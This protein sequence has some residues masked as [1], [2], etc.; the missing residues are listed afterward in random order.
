MPAT[1]FSW[2]GEP[3]VLGSLSTIATD[4]PDFTEASSTVG[5][6]VAQLEMG[7]TYTR[8]A[9]IDAHS[10][11][12]L[13]LRYGVFANWL[14]LR[15][16]VSPVSVVSDGTYSGAEDLYLGTKLWLMQ[17]DEW[18]PEVAVVYQMTV[19]TGSPAFTSG[20]VLP[21][22]NVLY[23]WDISD[24]FSLAGST[25]YNRAV[26][27]ESELYDE[28]S[29]SATVGVSLLDNVG[30]Y[31]EWFAFI[32]G[33]TPAALPEH[34]INGGLT[35]QLNDDLQFDV[36]IGKGLSDASEDFFAGAG[37]AFRFR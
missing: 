29:Q 26:D 22:V 4:R 16:A 34:Y 25:Q 32:P 36:R 14:E 9:K 21:G 1:I 35:Y 20:H 19:P 8:S 18:L 27:E 12:E 2:S 23:G 28:W 10:W 5:L 37:I 3:A 13:L 24:D 31:M 11:G 7:Y 17:Q 33:G 15:A 30:A 6:G